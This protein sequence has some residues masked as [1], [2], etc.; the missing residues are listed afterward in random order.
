MDSE[1]VVRAQNGDRAAYAS[2]AEHIGGRFHAT[3]FSVLRDRSLA[4]DATQQALVNVWRNLPRL[5]DPDRFEAWSY[6][7][8]VN[9]C[10]AQAKAER[11]WMP[12]LPAPASGH[13]P[14]AE[15]DVGNVIDRDQLERAFRRLSV[16]QRTAV[17]LR[18]YLGLSVGQVADAVDAPIETVRSRL[19]HALR[20]MRSAIEADA[21]S[22]LDAPAAP[23]GAVLPADVD[24]NGGPR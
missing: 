18:H 15:D 20:A 11:R 23:D 16:D 24:V 6:R 4:E 7:L 12:G 10:Y 8:L 13:E 22:P 17:V 14:V 19:R 5:R 3:A 1:V 9:A 21:R 2:L